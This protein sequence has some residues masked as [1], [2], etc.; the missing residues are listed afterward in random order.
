MTKSRHQ[1][2]P[3][4]LLIVTDQHAPRI[5]GFAGDSVVQTQHLDA[6][7]A[8][9]VQFSAA[10]CASPVCTPSRMCLLTGKEAHRCSAWNNHWVIFPEHV[11]WPAHFAAHG[12]RTCLV[13][14]MHFGGR[15]QMQGFQHRPYGDLRHGLGHQPDP[16][17]L[18]PSYSG[19]LGAGITEIPES[20]LQDVVVTRET[21]AF[22]LEHQD[23]EPDTPWFCCASYSRPH[24]P[25][26]APGRYLR[27]YRDRVPPL[28]VPDDLKDRL[29]PY[30]QNM[31]P[32]ETGGELS[33]Q[34]S[35]RARE[36]YY[37]CVD[38][39]DDCIGE[40]LTGLE[41]SGLLENTIVIY[42]SDHGEMAGLH[43]LWGKGVYFESSIGVPLLMCGPGIAST[44][45]HVGHPLSLMDLFPTT[46]ALAGL[47]VPPGLDGVDFSGVLSDPAA[48]PAPR[49]FAASSY[50]AWGVRVRGAVGAAEDEPCRAMRLIRERDWKYIEIEGAAP[51]LFDL[52]TDPDE[53]INLADQP[54]Y[55]DR[56]RA[57]RELLFRGFS[58]QQVHAQ[59]D[60]DR[61]RVAQFLSGQKPT[62]PN[63]YMLPD[64]RIFDAEGDLYGA[65]WLH[66]PPSPGGGIIPQQFG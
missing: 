18:F 65:R 32:D 63:Q 37:A 19:P 46:S 14:K 52:Q 25:F 38:F 49:Q 26:T 20:L 35:L 9:S 10:V 53:N 59:L 29:D 23:A 43:G 60:K 5:A 4:I 31:L 39:V 12:Y 16:I 15:D 40:L 36:A 41:A 27:R 30:A 7:A 61:E 13:G 50:F 22:L 64:G 6:L 55:A 51:L 54:R 8:R 57:M 1:Y 58:W 21:L 48:A 24:S 47:P 66:L 28:D 44:N 3:N 11:T 45:S 2:F 33:S 17:D 34:Q 56:C 62:T 42:T